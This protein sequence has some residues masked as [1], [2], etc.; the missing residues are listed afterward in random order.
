MSNFELADVPQGRAAAPLAQKMSASPGAITPLSAP[1]R[2][3]INLVGLADYCR[4]RS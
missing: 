4:P 3:A 2:D 1:H